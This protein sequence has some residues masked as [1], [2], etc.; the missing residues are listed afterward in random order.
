V[1]KNAPKV[2]AVR[3]A[4]TGLRTVEIIAV[5]AIIGFSMTGCPADPEDDGTEY[6]SGDAGGDWT[7]NRTVYGSALTVDTGKTSWPIKI[8][9]GDA[10]IIFD[11]EP[12]PKG[13]GYLR[14][15]VELHSGF[16][17]PRTP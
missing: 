11:E 7:G 4:A 6:I 1:K 8:T 5:V 12:R 16:N 9:D 2:Q 15:P 13:T 10:V 14:S 17:T 3:K